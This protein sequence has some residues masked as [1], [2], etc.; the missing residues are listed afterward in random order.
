MGQL[1]ISWAWRGDADNSY[2]GRCGEVGTTM[3]LG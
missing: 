3:A 2:C 1:T